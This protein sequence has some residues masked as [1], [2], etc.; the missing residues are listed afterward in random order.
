MQREKPCLRP[1]LSSVWDQVYYWSTSRLR[2][3][4][5]HTEWDVLSCCVCRAHFIQSHLL[6]VKALDLV[7]WDSFDST[8]I[9]Q[10]A[11]QYREELFHLN[12][13]R[14]VISLI[15]NLCCWQLEL[16]GQS[17]YDFVH[18]CDQEELRDLLTPRPGQTRCLL[19]PLNKRPSLWLGRYLIR[20][21]LSEKKNLSCIS[22]V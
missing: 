19:S 5:T 4:R 20:V 21:R 1:I 7:W 16:L 18:P 3:Q 6:Q 13:H 9:R 10:K 17:V 2:W 11:Q 15:S 12:K 8:A 14:N 22:S